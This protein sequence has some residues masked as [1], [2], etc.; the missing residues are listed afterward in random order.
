M[1]RFFVAMSFVVAGLLIT[2]GTNVAQDKKDEKKKEVVL[3]GK[4][5]CAKC[6]LATSDKCATVIVVKD[7]KSKKDVVYFF[8]KASHDKYHD[9]ICTTSKTGTVTV[10]VTDADKKKVVSV[11]KLAYD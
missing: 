11:K 9:D 8:D 6:D 7:A 2:A 1:H 10:V 5:T 4:I 3:K